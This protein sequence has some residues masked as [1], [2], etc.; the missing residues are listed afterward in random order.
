MQ[1]KN[2]VV[3]MQVLTGT[4]GYRKVLSVQ[5]LHRTTILILSGGI[6]MSPL[7]NEDMQTLPARDAKGRF[8]PRVHLVLAYCAELGDIVTTHVGVKAAKLARA[9]HLEF[10]PNG[11]AVIA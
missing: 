2:V 11:S 10:F 4:K 5:H 9:L 8:M 6:Y 3:G 1:A 7:K